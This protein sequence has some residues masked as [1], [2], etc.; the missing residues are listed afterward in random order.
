MSCTLERLFSITSMV[1]YVR[2][3]YQ[4]AVT[5]ECNETS[6]SSEEQQPTTVTI[7]SIEA[8]DENPLPL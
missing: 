7:Q 3:R 1:W 8:E 4:S 6:Q 2:R 5:N